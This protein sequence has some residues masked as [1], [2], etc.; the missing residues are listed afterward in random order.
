[1]I[2]YN[3]KTEK[4]D[5]KSIKYMLGIG[6]HDVEDKDNGSGIM[7]KPHLVTKCN[8]HKKIIIQK[9]QSQY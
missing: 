2:Y 4:I 6:W 9:L 8:S 7:T 3:C 5:P 1:M